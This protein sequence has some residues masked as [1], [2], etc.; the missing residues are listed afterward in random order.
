MPGVL[1]LYATREGHTRKVASRIA[2]GLRRRG[3]EV[4]LI[5]AAN[6]GATAS[7]ELAAFDLIV[8]GASMHAGGIEPEIVRFV[9]QHAEVISRQERSL[10]LVLLSVATKDPELREKSLADARAKL[11]RQIRVDFG[12]PEMIAGALSY[13]KYSWPIKAIMRRIAGQAGGDT[14]TSRDYEYTDWDQVDAY[15]ARLADRLN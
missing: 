1:V 15:A 12:K 2:D 11:A 7:L 4:A 14:D 5:D 9:A 3:A 8:V 13:S 6:A 10:F